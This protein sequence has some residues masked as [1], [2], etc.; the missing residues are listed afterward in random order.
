VRSGNRD[1]RSDENGQRSRWVLDG[2]VP[3]RQVPVENLVPVALVDRRIKKQ[4]VSVE[5]VLQSAPRDQEGGDCKRRDEGC[6]PSLGREVCS[7]IRRDFRRRES[8][9][10]VSTTP[11]CLAQG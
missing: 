3:V 5:A 6:A 7:R 4:A 9:V 8:G 11:L 10:A 1:G 2:K